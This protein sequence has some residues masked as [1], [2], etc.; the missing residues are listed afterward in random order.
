[1]LVST[2]LFGRQIIVID[3]TNPASP[4]R[5]GSLTVPGNV[6]YFH[7]LPD[8]QALVLSSRFDTV[9][10]GKHKESRSWVQAHLLDVS[11]ADAPKVLD[12]WERPWSGDD[13]GSDHHAFTYWPSRK[14]AMWGVADT[15]PLR[16][17][18]P[19]HATV[20]STDGGVHEVAVPVANKPNAVP[21]PCPS[22]PVPSDARELVGPDAIV[23]ACQDATRRLVVW[24]RYECGRIS[25]DTVAHFVPE[26]QL[27]K[28]YFTCNPAPQ[29]H[30]ARVLVVAGR[31]ILYT[32][33][34]L[35]ALD[36]T[37]FASVSIAYHRTSGVYGYGY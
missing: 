34:T 8:G 17:P 2:G 15:Q 22:V 19:N 26:D 11:D 12:T 31:P 16:D 37:T 24:P 36:P 10:S 20:I 30:V 28:A 5:A 23:L 27:D 32:D 33:Q 21:P 4:R 7:P 25:K 1:V 6:E 9:G 35:E 13:V 18:A 14:L 3:V 29:P